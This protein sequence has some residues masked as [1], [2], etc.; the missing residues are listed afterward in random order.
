LHNL[1]FDDIDVSVLILFSQKKEVLVSGD[2]RSIHVHPKAIDVF[3]SLVKK[4]KQ[5]PFFL[6]FC[7]SPDKK[8]PLKRIDIADIA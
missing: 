4:I 6:I 1:V 5:H 3:A 7:R 8:V 2:N